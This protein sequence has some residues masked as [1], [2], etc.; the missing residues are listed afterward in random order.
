M[1]VSRL[2]LQWF[3]LDDVSR[4]KL[5]LKLE[6]LSVLSKPDKL[7]QVIDGSL[8]PSPAVHGHDQSRRLL[9]SPPKAL[10]SIK[11]DREHASDGLSSALLVVFLDSARNL[12]VS[13]SRRESHTFQMMSALLRSVAYLLSESLLCDSSPL[14]LNT[15]PRLT[16]GTLV[17]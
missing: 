1:N 4:G 3:V 5:H 6:W 9:L 11:A 14:V 8:A 2:H 13:P 7:D 12:P 17:Q 16:P 10:T 15:A